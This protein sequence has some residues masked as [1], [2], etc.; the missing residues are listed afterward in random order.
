[1]TNFKTFKLFLTNSNLSLSF[2]YF[3]NK[4]NFLGKTFLSSLLIFNQ[5]LMKY[6]GQSIN[7]KAL[8]SFFFTYFPFFLL[9][10]FSLFFSSL[11]FPK[12]MPLR[13]KGYVQLWGKVEQMERG[14]GCIVGWGKRRRSCYCWEMIQELKGW[15][16]H[17]WIDP[18]ILWADFIKKSANWNY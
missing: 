17:C 1:M 9:L 15:S 11:F 5:T 8:V 6:G 3:C 7:I 16:N 13:P 14:G 10:P 4:F 12:Q 2:H 18:F